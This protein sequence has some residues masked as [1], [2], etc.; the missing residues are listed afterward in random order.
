MIV[1][2]SIID[3]VRK[4]V[5]NIL[6]NDLSSDMIYHS[7]NHTKEVVASAMEIAEKQGVDED[8]F[9]I[10]QIA[11][12]F[13]DLGF[14]KGSENHEVHGGELAESFLLNLE[15]PQDKIDKVKGCILATRMPQNPKNNLEKILCDAD[16]MHL[17]RKDYFKKAELLHKEMEKVK[18]CKI[19]DIEW[20]RM[21]KEFLGNHCFFTDYARENYESGVKNNLEKVKQRLNSWRKKTK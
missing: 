15:Y 19:S 12:W 4:Y 10:I 2:N 11:G 20:L 6:E 5:M 14:V 16:L 21:N 17:A 18:P 1:K 3:E 8:Q 13:H 7:I 9:E